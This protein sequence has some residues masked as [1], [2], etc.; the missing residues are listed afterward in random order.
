MRS[1]AV[2]HFGY[3]PAGS[4][5]DLKITGRK[6]LLLHAEFN[7]FHRV[8]RANGATLVLI[9]FD[10]GGQY[11]SLVRFGCTFF[12]LEDRFKLM[13]CRPQVTSLRMGLIVIHALHVDFV[14]LRMSTDEFHPRNTRSILH[15]DHQ[16][17][18]VPANSA[19]AP[20]KTLSQ[21]S[22][23]PV[24]G[25]NEWLPPTSP[26]KSDDAGRE[27]GWRSNTACLPA[28]NS[29]P[30]VKF[31]SAPGV[32]DIPPFLRNPVGVSNRAPG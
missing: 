9:G 30:R 1:L 2:E 16:T 25:G 17:V 8:S 32:P 23:A 6:S 18:L 28:S 29:V 31:R 3:P 20:P 24:G 21:P 10:Q 13:E 19:R 15:F 4:D 22:L 27:V 11:F 7:R 14:V 5:K 12:R 26:A